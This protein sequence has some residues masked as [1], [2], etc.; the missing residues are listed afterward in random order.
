MFPENQYKD[1]IEKKIKKIK[2]NYFKIFKYSPNPEVLD[3]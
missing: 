2:F 1:F 3:W